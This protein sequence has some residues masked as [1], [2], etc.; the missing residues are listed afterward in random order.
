MSPVFIH[1]VDCSQDKETGV[2]KLDTCSVSRMAA[3]LLIMN[4]Q[5]KIF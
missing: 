5:E 3:M 1:S 2:F 4:E